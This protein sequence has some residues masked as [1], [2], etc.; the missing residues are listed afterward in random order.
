MGGCG[1]IPSIT[2]G[3]QA[4]PSWDIRV[5]LLRDPGD[6]VSRTR[7]ELHIGPHADML[8]FPGLWHML[9]VGAW[10]RL[11]HTL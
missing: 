1:P 4:S 9:A 7:W 8:D 11:L 2:I 10:P 5:K 3:L 6:F